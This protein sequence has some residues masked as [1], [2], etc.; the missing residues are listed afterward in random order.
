MTTVLAFTV[1][2]L[3]SDAS[4]QETSW[5]DHLAVT[6]WVNPATPSEFQARVLVPKVGGGA[7]NV[8]GAHVILLG[9][10]GSFHRGITDDHGDVVISGVG[11]GVYAMIARAPGLVAVYAMHV[12]A[13]DQRGAAG[14]PGKAE[15]ACAPLSY[16]KFA[17]TVMP[18]LRSQY[19]REALTIEDA[20]LEKISGHVRGNE[21]YQ[22]VR[23]GGGL[24]GYLYAATAKGRIA[25]PDDLD[26]RLDPAALMSVFLFRN[27]RDVGRAMTDELG[28]FEIPD[29]ATGVYALVTV[30]PDGLGAV[31]FELLEEADSDKKANL[32]SKDG[33]KFVSVNGD[34]ENSEFELQVIPVELPASTPAVDEFGNLLPLDG[35]IGGSGGVGGSDIAGLAALAAALAAAGGDSGGG[36]GTGNNN[37]AVLPPRISQVRQVPSRL[38]SAYGFLV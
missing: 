22:V 35:S 3:P 25:D 9:R 24:V 28:R 5:S 30:G 13:A 12:I 19:D 16:D 18:L 11:S 37:N 6:Q 23:S 26:D 32:V 36:T 27:G 31:G 34:N 33:Y 8:S 1:T 14:Y 4:A 29:L 2:T 15:I 20:N 21:R 17:T 38:A 7:R 10:N